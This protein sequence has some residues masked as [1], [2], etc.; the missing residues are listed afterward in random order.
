MG[1]VGWIMKFEWEL[2]K[3]SGFWIQ[4]ELKVVPNF[5]NIKELKW[6]PRWNFFTQM[7]YDSPTCLDSYMWSMKNF[8]SGLF[9]NFSSQFISG[10]QFWE[11]FDVKIA[12]FYSKFCGKLIKICQKPV[13]IP[14]FLY[15]IK[16]WAF[17]LILGAY[18][19]YLEK[20]LMFPGCMEN[21][22][23]TSFKWAYLEK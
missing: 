1:K 11:F 16:F 12:H 17:G 8:I 6:F 7:D 19:T 20:K 9:C 4:R 3:L 23:F 13:H 5:F 18:G 21:L 14:N 15:W 2:H 10:G 22:K